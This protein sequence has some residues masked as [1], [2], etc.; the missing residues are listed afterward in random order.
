[1]DEFTAKFRFDPSKRSYLGIEEEVWTVHPKSGVLIPGALDVFTE[2][3]EDR[4]PGFKPELPAQQLEAVT[5]P[6]A[7][8]AELDDALA[9]NAA[10]MRAMERTYGFRVS[11]EPL[12]TKPFE[13]RVYPTP[14]YLDI[15]RS[16][17][18]RLR[19]AYVAGLHVHVGVGGTDE[20][21]AVMNGCRTLLPAFLA[22]S[23]RS[24]GTLDGR[25][26]RSCRFVKYR[27]MAV[28][29]V[30]PPLRTWEDFAAYAALKG[31]RD[32]PRRC[33]WAIRINP[34][35]TVELRVCDVQSDRRRTLGIAAL[36]RMFARA[37]VL[38]AETAD[39]ARVSDIE[40]ALDLAARGHFDRD[41]FL[42]N[43]LKLASHRT[44]KDE[45]P[46]VRGLLPR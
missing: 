9:A 21:L 15:Q 24:F 40:R 16:V 26:Y 4:W 17:G 44:F 8:L 46:Y 32:D 6:C 11:R 27:E 38:G 42:K 45:R 7:T 39:R 37:F 5:P 41:A 36:F 12:P 10:Q 3:Y 30:P 13:I 35:G 28:D 31:F 29:V 2:G 34:V 25:E 14:R 22:F 43:A 20:A 18:E 19:G 23:A 33:W 1:M